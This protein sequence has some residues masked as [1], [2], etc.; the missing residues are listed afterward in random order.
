MLF[1]F[2]LAICPLWP[3]QNRHP[4]GTSRLTHWQI[5][6]E[7]EPRCSRVPSSLQLVARSGNQ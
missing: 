2:T 3:F 6:K 1:P 7:V 4:L 5:E